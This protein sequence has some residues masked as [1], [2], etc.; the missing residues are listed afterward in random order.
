VNGAES[1]RRFETARVARLATV[2]GDGHP[3][4]VPIVFALS[5]E[6]VYS[7]VDD[8]PKRTILLRRLHNAASNPWVSVLADHYDDTD[9]SALWWA[10]A[11]G[12]ARVLDA[13]EPEAREAIALLG[14]R[15]PQQSAR[16]PVMA[17]D[18]K[19]WSGWA[20]GSDAAPA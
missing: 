20:A 10:R 9:W 1:R 6:I 7:V 15:Y 19:R 8:K 14:R 11:D 2:D 5:G 3:H 12:M 13:N 16:G 18:V 17:V 4:L